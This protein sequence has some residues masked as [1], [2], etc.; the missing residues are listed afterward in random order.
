MIDAGDPD[1]APAPSNLSLDGREWTFCER[2]ARS[3]ARHRLE[4]K[5]MAPWSRSI[6]SWSRPKRRPHSGIMIRPTD[7]QA[8]PPWSSN[9]LSATCGGIVADLV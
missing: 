3:L 5:P 6:R 4:L 1:E 9:W 2:A 7:A 8:V